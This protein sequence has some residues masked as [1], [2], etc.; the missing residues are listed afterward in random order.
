MRAHLQFQSLLPI[1]SDTHAPE[2]VKTQGEDTAL[3]LRA[4][5]RMI[6]RDGEGEARSI[7]HIREQDV[8]WLLA[9]HRADPRVPAYLDGWADALRFVLGRHQ[10]LRRLASCRRE[11]PTGSSSPCPT[12]CSARKSS[13][14]AAPRPPTRSPKRCCQA[15]NASDAC[16]PELVY[17]YI[18]IYP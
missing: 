11:S 13:T 2:L 12:S 14:C 16:C 7:R 15:T 3:N 18:Y 17:I 9:R 8:V 1:R 6:A 10:E 4:T 5:V